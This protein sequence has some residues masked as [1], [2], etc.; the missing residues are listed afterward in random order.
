MTNTN[1][2]RKEDIEPKPTYNQNYENTEVT[3]VATPNAGYDFVNWTENDEVISDD[4]VAFAVEY[5][6]TFIHTDEV[7]A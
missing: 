3:L 2:R 6:I 4:S 5:E 1:I 7:I